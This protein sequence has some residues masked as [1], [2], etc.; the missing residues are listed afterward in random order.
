MQ[1]EDEHPVLRVLH[2]RRAAGSRPGARTDEYR[3]GLAV[4]GGAVRGVVSGGMLVALE[5]RG[6]RDAFDVVYGSSAG[7]FNAAYFLTG[8][9][10]EALS[11]YYQQMTETRFIDVWRALLGRPIVSLDL[12]LE[13][14][15]K[16]DVPLDWDAL[17]ASPIRFCVLASSVDDVCP[18]ALTDFRAPDDL[19]TAL[20]GGATIP[21]VAGPPVEFRARRLLDAAVLLA[22]PYE[23]AIQDGCTHVLSLSTRPRGAVRNSGG[24]WE[25]LTAW[26]LDRLHEGLGAGYR[27]R[28]S[29]YGRAQV[30]LELLTERPKAPPYVYDVA[31]P[32]GVPEVPRLTRDVAGIL[33]GATQGYESAI[34]A[35]EGRTVRG[36]LTLVSKPR[37]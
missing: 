12:V 21:Y 28:I 19:R 9:A 37:M 17:V 8:Q 15:M 35:V 7:S 14:A 25:R 34:L 18:V 27:S 33:A 30:A 26:R 1:S 10:W 32:R 31:P 23:S 4:E 16:H 6:Y 11:L 24:P 29:G 36:V 3:V 5:E 20:R 13:G 2:E 22:H